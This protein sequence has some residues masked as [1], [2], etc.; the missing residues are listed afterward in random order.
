MTI[1][2][3][4]RRRVRMIPL[5]VAEPA[6]IRG[7]LCAYLA[8]LGVERVHAEAW[9]QKACE[10]AVSGGEAF[11]RLREILVADLAARAPNVADD[12]ECA[13]LARLSIWLRVKPATLATLPLTPPLT[14]QPMA[15]ERVRS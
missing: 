14:R 13:A 1:D 5:D 3:R 12:P 2:E 11:A 4:T 8:I 7:R 10:G 15:S 9:A 6:E